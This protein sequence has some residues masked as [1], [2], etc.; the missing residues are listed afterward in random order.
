RESPL[1]VSPRLSEGTRVPAIGNT[2]NITTGTMTRKEVIANLKETCQALDEKK[3]MLESIITA[4]ELEEANEVVD[5]EVD[6]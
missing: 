3:A 2:S 4:L 6:A 5:E 1:T